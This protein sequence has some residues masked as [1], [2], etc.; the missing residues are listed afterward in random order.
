MG[1][2]FNNRG[3]KNLAFARA[4]EAWFHAMPIAFAFALLAAPAHATVITIDVDNI[5]KD[6][7]T[8]CQPCGPST[9]TFNFDNNAHVLNWTF[10]WYGWSGMAHDAYAAAI[11]NGAD[12]F[13][14]GENDPAGLDDWLMDHP[15]GVAFSRLDNTYGLGVLSSDWTV[16]LYNLGERQSTRHDVLQVGPS[17]GFWRTDNLDD[18]SYYQSTFTV[19]GVR[20]EAPP[21][22]PEPGTL[23]LFLSAA[24][25]GLSAKRWRHR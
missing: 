20:D 13:D 8:V 24:A 23:G 21:P 11:A 25:I 7:S 19:T 6:L 5:E 15:N 22:V 4:V 16:T 17:D 1:R 12:M 18:A 14:L 3:C 2:R 9:I 10:D